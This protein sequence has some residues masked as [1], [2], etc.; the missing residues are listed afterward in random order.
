MTYG[1]YLVKVNIGSTKPVLT[2]GYWSCRVHAHCAAKVC[3]VQ[4]PLF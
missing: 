3:G 1:C 2:R 4:A